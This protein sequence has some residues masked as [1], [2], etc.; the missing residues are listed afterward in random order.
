MSVKNVCENEYV[1]NGGTP[2][3]PP[4]AYLLIAVTTH[5]AR[6]PILLC[7][8]SSKFIVVFVLFY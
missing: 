1:A 7:R 3:P 4:P 5:A 6:I 2:L 8:V